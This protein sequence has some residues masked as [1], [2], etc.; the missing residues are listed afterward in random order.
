M[1][2]VSTV[3]ETYKPKK[4]PLTT[5]VGQMRQAAKEMPHKD[6]G[7]FYKQKLRLTLRELDVSI[8]FNLG[9]CKCFCLW[10]NREWI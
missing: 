3:E 10:I 2:R 5:P 7:F 1:G 6:F 8:S 4:F 9:I